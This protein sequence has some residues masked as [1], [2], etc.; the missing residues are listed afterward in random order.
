MVKLHP[1]RSFGLGLYF[2][3]EDIYPDEGMELIL[4]HTHY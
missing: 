2:E 4:L 1:K 3:K